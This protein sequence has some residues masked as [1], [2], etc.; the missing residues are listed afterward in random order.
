MCPA[1]ALWMADMITSLVPESGGAKRVSPPGRPL[2][3]VAASSPGATV[4]PAIGKTEGSP[5]HNTRYPPAVDGASAPRDSATL[6][7]ARS[8]R[9]LP[10]LARKGRTAT[11]RVSTETPAAICRHPKPTSRRS[12]SSAPMPRPISAAR[13]VA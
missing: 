8:K 9:P 6:V 3:D 1:I 2:V 12:C 5:N 10:K 11:T 7:V 13:A 4:Q